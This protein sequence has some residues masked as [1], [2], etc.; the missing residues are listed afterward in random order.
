MGNDAVGVSL[1]LMV[2][3]IAAHAKAVGARLVTRD[4]AFRCVLSGEPVVR[5]VPTS[6]KSASDFIPGSAEAILNW[7]NDFP[8]PPYLQRSAE[9]INQMIID[10]RAAWD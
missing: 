6:Q 4:R 3:M 1:V 10:E 9:E 5:L 2:V 8:L 7:R